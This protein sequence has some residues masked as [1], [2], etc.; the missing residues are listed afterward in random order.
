MRSFARH[1]I[2]SD[3]LASSASAADRAAA[4]PVTDTLRPYLATLMGRGGVRALLA[5]ALALATVEVSWLRAV[6]VNA[7]GDLEGLAEVGS[8]LNPTDFLEGRVVLLAQLLGLLVAF[9][10]PG[11]TSRLV[12]EF[13]PQIPFQDLDFGKEQRDEK[14]T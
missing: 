7:D 3:A 1:L 13:W 12:G 10:G 6:H 9:I 4:F 5:R 8:V 11:L 14:A 2:V